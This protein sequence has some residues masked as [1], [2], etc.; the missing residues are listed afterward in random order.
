[1]LE[2]NI[3]DIVEVNTKN[4]IYKDSNGCEKNIDLSLCA[5]YLKAEYQALD[6]SDNCVGTASFPELYL[7]TP[8]KICLYVY[9]KPLNKFQKIISQIIDWNCYMKEFAVFFGL[10][11]KLNENGWKTFDL[12]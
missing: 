6:L 1:M 8:E 11:K 12:T 10:Q 5:K 3:E 4:I 2:I 9:L 7:Y